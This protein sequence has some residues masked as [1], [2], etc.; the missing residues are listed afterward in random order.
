MVKQIINL[1]LSSLK[2]LSKH[3][4]NMTFYA[5]E[6][7]MDSTPDEQFSALIEAT[8]NT[9]IDDLIIHHDWYGNSYEFRIYGTK[10]FKTLAEA[11]KE[12]RTVLHIEESRVSFSKTTDKQFFPCSYSP[13]EVYVTL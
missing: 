4:F 7:V 12:L 10:G 13:A 1:P 3:T 9:T 8:K 11:T 2:D 5:L 6:S